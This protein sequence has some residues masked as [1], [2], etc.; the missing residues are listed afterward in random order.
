MTIGQSLL[1]SYRE[2]QRSWAR[3]ADSAFGDATRDE[4]ARGEFTSA[5]ITERGLTF[6]KSAGAERKQS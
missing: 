3:M 6:P 4:A 1:Q 2:L 5:F